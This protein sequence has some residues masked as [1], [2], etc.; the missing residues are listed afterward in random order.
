MGERKLADYGS[1]FMSGIATFH[2]TKE[3]RPFAPLVSFTFTSP[4]KLPNPGVNSTA[5]LSL[6]MWRAGRTIDEIAAERGLSPVT[7]EGHLAPAIANGE[8][9]NPRVFYTA[10]EEEENPCFPHVS[11]LHSAYLGRAGDERWLHPLPK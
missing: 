5:Q 8:A 3:C 2:E 1:V 9:I 10:E 7:I 11:P 4:P 6:E